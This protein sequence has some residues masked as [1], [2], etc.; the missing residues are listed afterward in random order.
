MFLVSEGVS[1][2]DIYIFYVNNFCLGIIFLLYRDG[3]AL[4]RKDLIVEWGW[5]D[6]YVMPNKLSE[7]L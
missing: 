1:G 3:K 6:G 7:Y 2:V 5:L 4:Y